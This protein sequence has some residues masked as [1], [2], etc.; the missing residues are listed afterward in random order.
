VA[1]AA[2]LVL[3]PLPVYTRWQPG[4][5]A[6]IC[7][8]FSARAGWLAHRLLQAAQPNPRASLLL[9]LPLFLIAIIMLLRAGVNALA[10]W[11]AQGLLDPTPFNM[12]F[13]WGA[14][15]LAVVQNA[16]LAFLV[17]MR[18][19]LR[20][21]HL[22]ERD[23]LTEVLNR[24]AFE[25]AL[26]RAHEALARGQA[27][28]LVMI[29]MDHFKRLNDTLGHPAGDAAL[30]LL[31]KTVGPCVRA[32]D[33]LGRLGGEEFCLLLP[34]TE[35]AGATLVAERMRGLLEGCDFQ[36]EGKSWPLSASF[37]VA[38]ALKGE[39]SGELVMARADAA[40]YRAKSQ[41]RN[42]VQAME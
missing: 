33:R 14:L 26:G 18:L 6:L 20:I 7:A 15:V 3:L 8:V 40:L 4:L 1:G 12:A 27:Y 35:L 28:A 38:E 42:V 30:R 34:A 21:R 19:V 25:R 9:S 11:H 5:T 36:W 41:G 22:T 24:H 31:V 39:A 29:D 17:L 32:I 16:T 37:G 13:L 10:P 23:A 2:L